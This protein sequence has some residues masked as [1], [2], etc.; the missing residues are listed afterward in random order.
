MELRIVKNPIQD[1]G[2]PYRGK[3][4]DEYVESIIEDNVF[5]KII[6]IWCVGT[7]QYKES[8]G[9]LRR[10]IDYLKEVDPEIVYLFDIQTLVE[11]NEIYYFVRADLQ[12]TKKL[13]GY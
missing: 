11:N 1:N 6:P 5:K 13:V 3:P 2:I 10:W 8:D 12:K 7:Y 9:G 4:D